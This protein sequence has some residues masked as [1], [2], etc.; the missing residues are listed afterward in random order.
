MATYTSVA[1][2]NWSDSSRWTPVGVPGLTDLV[3]IAAG[4]TIIIISDHGFE[5]GEMPI[6]YIEPII[7]TRGRPYGQGHVR[8]PNAIIGS[9]VALDLSRPNQRDVFKTI[10]D[11]LGLPPAWWALDGQSLR[12]KTANETS[13][14]SKQP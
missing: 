8:E 5:I 1:T 4:H 10:V 13:I 12:R 2:G 7:P 14:Q 9:T 11:V 6:G 3:R